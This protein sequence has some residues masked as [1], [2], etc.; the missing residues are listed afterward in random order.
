M[1]NVEYVMRNFVPR[2]EV[3]FSC[4]VSIGQR[5]GGISRWQNV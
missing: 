1:R 4:G 2:Y 3:A 5:E